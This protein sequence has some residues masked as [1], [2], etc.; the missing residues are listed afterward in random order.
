M[1]LLPPPCSSLFV[2]V[3]LCLKHLYF[4]LGFILPCS[5][6]SSYLPAIVFLFLI[7]ASVRLFVLFVSFSISPHHPSV[8][9]FPLCLYFYF[10]SWASVS[11]H[12]FSVF[13]FIYLSVSGRL[14]ASVLCWSF[15]SPCVLCICAA[16]LCPDSSLISFSIYSSVFL[17]CP[18]MSFIYRRLGIH[19]RLTFLLW[20]FISYLLIAFSSFLH[21]SLYLSRHVSIQSVFSRLGCF[22]FPSVY[23]RLF[24]PPLTSYFLHL[25]RRASLFSLGIYLSPPVFITM[26]R[27]AT[28]DLMLS[29]VMHSFLSSAEG[30][31]RWEEDGEREDERKWGEM[32]DK[33]R[34]EWDEDGRG[35]KEGR[36]RCTRW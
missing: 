18:Y 11:L 21:R 14:C 34:G 26:L 13:F 31:R 16:F 2:F 29:E 6:S 33:P 22:S 8:C 1:T 25:S 28:C 17:P 4:H 24:T 3:R 27:V 36:R 15:S 30:K 35:R 12:F 5:D 20:L 10:S 19:P 23:L 32:K 9:S 7:S